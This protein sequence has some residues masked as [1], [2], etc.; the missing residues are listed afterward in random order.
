MYL[1]RRQ[2]LNER[3]LRQFSINQFVL[4]FYCPRL[5]IA[6]EID[7]DIHFADGDIIQYDIERQKFIET[8]GIQFLRFRNDDVFSDLDGVMKS[9][10]IKVKELQSMN[11]S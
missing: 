6:I 7:G 8:L 3:F 9:I 2:I 1:R 10:E 5:R 11:P 4:D